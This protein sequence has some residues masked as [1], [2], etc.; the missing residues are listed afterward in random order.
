MEIGLFALDAE[1]GMLMLVILRLKGLN[2]GS[3]YFLILL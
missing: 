2:F 1:G 3:K